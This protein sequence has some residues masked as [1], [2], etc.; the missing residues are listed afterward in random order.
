MF[1][2]KIEN[3]PFT[4]A[5]INTEGF[6]T[7]TL[8]FTR[9]YSLKAARM[10]I[11]LVRMH[12]GIVPIDFKYRKFVNPARPEALSNFDMKKIKFKIELET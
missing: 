11:K 2:V 3:C 4:H 8:G 9:S 7:T 6:V 12:Y 5:S 1:I 10:I